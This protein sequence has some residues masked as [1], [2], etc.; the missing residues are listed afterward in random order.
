MV[1]SGFEDDN[2]NIFHARGVGLAEWCR[3]LGDGPEV[4]NEL[5]LRGGQ[6]CR[7]GL[8]ERG[9]ARFDHRP[10]RIHRVERAHLRG[11][12]PGVVDADGTSHRFGGNVDHQESD[13]RTSEFGIAEQIGPLDDSD[14]SHKNNG[15]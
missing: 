3:C 12:P 4:G 2:D 8:A 9:N 6:T 14:D 10:L 5:R 11:R 13:Q 15:Y 1:A 7:S